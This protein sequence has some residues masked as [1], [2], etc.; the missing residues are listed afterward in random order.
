MLNKLKILAVIPARSGSK[1][2]KN[3]NIKKVF[4]KPLIYYSIAHAKKIKLIDKVI[5]STDS[6]KYKSIAENYGAEVPF[7]R[8]KNISKDNSSDV[9]LFLHL[10]TWLTKNDSFFPDIC[11]HFRPTTPIRNVNE[12]IKAIKTLANNKNFD[13]LRS[14]DAYN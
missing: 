10:L 11:V 12:S 5:V 9:D 7:L 14:I 13:S 1:R 8:P 4:G 2:V 6:E 3:K